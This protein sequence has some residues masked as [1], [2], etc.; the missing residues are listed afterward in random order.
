MSKLKSDP[1]FSG[2]IVEIGEGV[3]SK[4]AIGQNVC[5]W[6]LLLSIT[7]G[8]PERIQCQGT[9]HVVHEQGEL[10]SVSQW[11]EEYMS[12]PQ[13]HCA[14]L[15]SVFRTNHPKAPFSRV[16]VG[17]VEASQNIYVLMRW[18]ST[19][20]RIICPVRPDTLANPCRT[21]PVCL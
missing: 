12:S 8:A 20:S 7:G 10:P 18:L 21:D 17:S 19:S 2:T 9:H 14:F 4:F 3:D 5:V 1:R 6:V 16:S 13:F 11:L 15:G